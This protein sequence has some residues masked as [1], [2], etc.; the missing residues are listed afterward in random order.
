MRIS[1]AECIDQIGS[2]IPSAAN[3]AHLLLDVFESLHGLDLAQLPIDLSAD[4]Q[5]VHQASFLGKH[6]T[7]A[8]INWI[9]FATVH[10]STLRIG[11]VKHLVTINEVLYIAVDAYEAPQP[12]D[13]QFRVSTTE[14]AA[15][16]VFSFL[17]MAYFNDL[18]V[19]SKT[20]E[21]VSFIE[22][23]F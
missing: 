20:A 21:L 12:Q 15:R 8:G 7:D 4:V 2:S 11:V 14:T 22:I 6:I 9:R 18:W 19:V 1:V 16:V 10:E 5:L 3:L 13:G 17:E 23:P